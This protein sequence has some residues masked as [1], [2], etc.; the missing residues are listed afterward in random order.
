MTPA[1]AAETIAATGMRPDR[2]DVI[3]NPPALPIPGAGDIGLPT[4]RFVL[5]VGRL[6]PQKRW[7]RLIGALP[8]LQDRE[9][10]LVLIGEG[11]ERERLFVQAQ[12]LGVGHRV[13]MPGYAA[14]PLPALTR[15]AVVALTSD[16][17]GVPGVLL[18]ARGVGTPVIATDSSPSI[19]EIISHPRIGSIVPRDD[20]A[21][22]VAALDY[23]LAPGTEPPAAVAPPGVDS[24]E[25]YLELFDR[26]VTAV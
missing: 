1:T 17:E 20:P 11:A 14:D 15:A 2:I 4:E 21:A 12:S 3:A 16:Y 22:L 5:G 9:I 10:L 25:R 26:V 7:D 23:W 6:A 8:E 24:V 19:A 18:E 13:L